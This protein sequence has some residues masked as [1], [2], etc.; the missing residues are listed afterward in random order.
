MAKAFSVASWNVEN[1][2]KK[3]TRDKVDRVVDFLKDK[4]KPDVFGI[5][6]VN[7]KDV[8]RA[9]TRKMSSYTFHITEGPQVQEILVG[10]KQTF[11]A[12]FT[13]KVEFRSGPAI[14]R[15]GAVLS[16]VVDGK[17]Y[18][19]LFL[20][21][22]SGTDPRGMG[23]RDDM[24]RRAAKFRASLNKMDKAAG[25]TGQANYIFLGDLN[26]MGM[27]YPFDRNIEADIE[28]RRLDGRVKRRKMRRLKKD[29]PATFWNGSQSAL[30]P[31]DLDHVVAANHL[32]FRQFGGKDVKLMGWPKEPTDTKKDRWIRDFSDHALLFFEVQKI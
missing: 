3:S 6:E 16:L 32:Q 13:Q 26:T 30:P 1:F 9:L 29:G 7:G 2:G 17:N 19:L 24:L 11:T 12:F 27:G 31:S 5:Y 22:K 21:T 18:T 15:P 25:G 4:A 8:F 20:H 28:L 10:V 14:L 23:L